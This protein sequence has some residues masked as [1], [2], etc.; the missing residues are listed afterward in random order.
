MKNCPNL[1][2]VN[3]TGTSVAIL[4]LAVKNIDISKS[5]YPSMSPEAKVIKEQGLGIMG[6]QFIFV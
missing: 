1:K 6:G 4:P 3:I 2:T 5:G